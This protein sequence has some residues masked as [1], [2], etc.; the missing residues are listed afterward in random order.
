M[1]YLGKSFCWN[2]RWSDVHKT[3][4]WNSLISRNFGRLGIL[5]ADDDFASKYSR[6]AF[7]EISK[8][9]T[10]LLLNVDQ[11]ISDCLEMFATFC[12]FFLRFS[13]PLLDL[14]GDVVWLH[15]GKWSLREIRS[16]AVHNRSNTW[17][18]CK[19]K[20]TWRMPVGLKSLRWASHT[21]M[22]ILFWKRTDWFARSHN[23]LR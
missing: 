16:I 13:N 12:S 6:A 23:N 11:T 7:L 8:F 2:R 21:R 1:A 14:N 20:R 4:I 5:C 9:W 19:H 15:A 17:R 3:V 10:H 22:I 18:S